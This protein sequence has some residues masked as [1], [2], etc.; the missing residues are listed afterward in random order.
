[1]QGKKDQPE[2]G[3]TPPPEDIP[4]PEIPSVCNRCGVP[5]AGAY[6]AGYILCQFCYRQENE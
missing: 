6:G 3:E 1:M 4:P 5:I 2:R